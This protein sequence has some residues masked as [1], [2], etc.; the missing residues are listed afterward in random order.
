MNVIFKKI[1]TAIKSTSPKIIC[2]IIATISI[3]VLGFLMLSSSWF[4]I[5]WEVVA[6]GL[7][8]I[9][10]AGEWYL[11]LNPAK[12][13]HELHHRRREL[14]FV[15]AVALGVLMEF[16]AL[17]HAIPEAI[18]LE[19]DVSEANVK[20]EQLRSDNASL[21]AIGQR[22]KEAASKAEEAAEN[23]KKDRLS[24]EKQVEEFR[25]T[26]LVLEA[27][28]LELKG[29]VQWRTIT[30][31]Q[32]TNLINLLRP[33]MQSNF[34]YRNLVQVSVSGDI[35]ESRQYAKRI[36]DVLTECGFD[37]ELDQSIKTIV[38]GGTTGLEF[39]VQ[40]AI[41]PPAH[42]NA[43]LNAF[44]TEKIAVT[45]T[46]KPWAPRDCLQIWVWPKPEK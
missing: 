6:A 14:Q 21:F 28:L 10:C 18:R 23:A 19:K 33:F 4:W 35:E 45:V 8:A 12:D 13:G 11:F 7:V 46:A 43:I 40:S 5:S 27:K 3:A 39:V 34:V 15:T 38:V 24:V 1:Q 44:K 16:F 42:A 20:V 29:I 31:E 26:N 32:E 2:G 41:R 30:P 25:Q 37:A 17:S 22:A 36:T 9:G